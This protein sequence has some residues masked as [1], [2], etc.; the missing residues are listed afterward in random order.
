MIL[1]PIGYFKSQ[2]KESYQAGR[3]PDPLGLHGTI[4]LSSGENYE[5]ALQDLIGCSHIWLIFGFHHNPNWK[6]LVQTPRSDRKIGVFAT[7]APYRPNPIGLSLVK[8]IDIKNLEIEVGEND[9][10][11]GSPIYDIKPYH[12]EH[13][14]AEDAHIEW[15]ESS[16]VQKHQISFSPLVE[17][18]LEFLEGHGLRE[19]KAFILRQLEYDPTNSD[20]KRV[21][22]NGHYWTL[23]YRTW[24]IDFSLSEKQI[25]IL[26][27][28]SGY[29]DEELQDLNTDTYQDKETHR[30]F[31]REF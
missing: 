13:D 24:R 4:Q 19:L 25:G 21:T 16:L 8:L 12:P 14:V 1:K 3:Q 11:D 7:R 6:P 9:L 27:I 5:Q 29:T 2:Q 23:A 20:K 17:S 26:S 10:L 28:R 22:S 18:Q 30:L 15:L 31:S